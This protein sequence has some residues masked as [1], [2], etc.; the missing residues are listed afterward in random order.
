[1]RR[2]HKV[3]RHDHILGGLETRALVRVGA[4]APSPRAALPSRGRNDAVATSCTAT[5]RPHVQRGRLSGRGR[6]AGEL[7]RPTVDIHPLWERPREPKVA[8][9]DRIANG[10][11]YQAATQIHGGEENVVRTV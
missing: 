4:I 1:M 8:H 5:T 6:A 2:K 10:R 7:G 11:R 9:D 3:G